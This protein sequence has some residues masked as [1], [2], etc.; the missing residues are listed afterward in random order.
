[1]V[2]YQKYLP[3]KLKFKKIHKQ[4][5]RFKGFYF[6]KFCYKH[7]P[8]IFCRVVDGKRLFPHHYE[9]FRR[10]VKRCV[11]KNAYFSFYSI[12]DLPVTNKK[13]GVRMGKGKAGVETWCSSPK[14]GFVFSTLG[15]INYKA[16]FFSFK[17]AIKKLPV[18]TRIVRNR[19]FL[20]K[21]KFL[22]CVE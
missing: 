4:L 19:F 2:V 11:K 6:S 15:N 7:D 5:Y 17:K 13:S 20:F 3:K 1:M 21:K 8:F 16:S 10:V 22:N 18:S 12:C 9:S 14:V